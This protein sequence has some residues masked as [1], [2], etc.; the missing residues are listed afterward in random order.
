LGSDARDPVARAMSWCGGLLF[1]GHSSRQSCGRARVRR[2][3][4]CIVVV[5]AVFFFACSVFF[6]PR[7]VWQ[8]RARGLSSFGLLPTS[9][10]RISF[11]G[12]VN[13]I[14]SPDGC[15]HHLHIGPKGFFSLSDSTVESWDP[16]A[17]AAVQA[18]AGR[19]GVRGCTFGTAAPLKGATAVALSEGVSRA[20]VTGNDLLGALVI[21]QT[22]DERA[23]IANNL[24]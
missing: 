18:S 10:R 8:D 17:P 24:A 14:R 13:V 20:V 11:R 19:I 2:L 12:C 22:A 1:G 7:V 5:V 23:V 16:K 21:S 9:R 6:P 4:P 15:C 3:F